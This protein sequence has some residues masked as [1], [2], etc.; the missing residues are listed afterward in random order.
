MCG[1][2]NIGAIV[3]VGIAFCH[4]HNVAVGMR[5]RFTLVWRGF[6]TETCHSIANKLDAVMSRGERGHDIRALM[7]MA[8]LFE[9]SLI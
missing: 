3:E 6:P 7:L 9:N 1:G 4:I 5:G 2:G 8:H